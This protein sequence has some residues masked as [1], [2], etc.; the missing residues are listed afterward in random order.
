MAYPDMEDGNQQVQEGSEKLNMYISP[1]MEA[2]PGTD[3]PNLRRAPQ[4]NAI[5][6][7]AEAS[8]NF[9]Q[10]NPI[11]KNVNNGFQ[12]PYEFMDFSTHTGQFKNG[13][14]EGQ[15]QCVYLDG[16]CYQGGWKNGF[17]HGD[18]VFAFSNGEIFVGYFDNDNALGSG[19]FYYK[20]GSKY[21]GKFERNMM[22]GPGE[23]VE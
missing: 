18:G 13:L 16:S 21:I 22:Q 1:Q 4:H 17:K 9:Y 3:L 7:L 12:G 5:A 20:D 8:L 23:I 2:T 14:R 15:G 6:D 10:K 19:T 11:Y